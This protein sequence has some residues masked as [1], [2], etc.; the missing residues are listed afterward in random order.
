MRTLVN[1]WE[2][3]ERWL[4]WLA[5]NVAWEPKA[6]PWTFWE[7]LV[8]HPTISAAW[9][10]RQPYGWIVGHLHNGRADSREAVAT[11]GLAHIIEAPLAL[12]LVFIGV[13]I[14]RRA[15]RFIPLS[16]ADLAKAPLRVKLDHAR[17]AKKEAAYIDRAIE[18]EEREEATRVLL[19]ELSATGWLRSTGWPLGYL[20][21]T[22]RMVYLPVARWW[23]HWQI[24]GG[25]GS[26]KTATQAVRGLLHAAEAGPAKDRLSALVF[27]PKA[28][29]EITRLTA[30]VF[31]ARGW[32]VGVWDPTRAGS[33]RWNSLAA[34]P[35][36]AAVRAHMM[37]WAGAAELRHPHY[38]QQA[39]DILTGVALM[40]RED[41]RADGK[42]WST[43][44]MGDVAAFF[45]AHTEEE[46]VAVLAASAR[47]ST[48]PAVKRTAAKL[49]AL[50][51]NKAS[52]EAVMRGVRDALVCLDDPQVR[53]NLRGD[54]ID[55]RAFVAEPTIIYAALDMDAAAGLRPVV[56]T[57]LTGAI[58][59]LTAVSGGR[60]LSRRVVILL[61]EFANLG[62]IDQVEKVASRVRALGIALCL[63]TQGP[64]DVLDV[65]GRQGRRLLANILTTVVLAKTPIE[66][67]KVFVEPGLGLDLD[68]LMESGSA[69]VIRSGE[70]PLHITPQGWYE[71]AG[72]RVRVWWLGRG[73]DKNALMRRQAAGHGLRR[74][75][76]SDAVGAADVGASW[77]ADAEPEEDDDV[78]RHVRGDDDRPGVEND[79]DDPVEGDN[80]DP[81]EDD[82]AR[83]PA[84]A[85]AR[86]VDL[87]W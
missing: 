32:R 6:A 25:T 71:S 23:E 1:L 75:P 59:A 31:R 39:A 46:A 65:Y 67:L 62:Q 42:A 53:E 48:D 21:G 29:H 12:F 81:P 84:S 56:A 11:M 37:Q 44:T 15:T 43:V 34:A 69:A 45:D 41:A 85:A 19:K 57:F 30:G 68:R 76:T 66:S 26:G 40:L 70:R 9:W 47:S 38:R 33:L 49:R 4:A 20:Q 74:A 50:E 24:I 54:D 27:D 78:E 60:R 22:T 8:A 55:W 77:A 87:R 61:D 36:P 63:L 13:L 80:D 2:A 64:R 35:S 83:E 82:A 51:A 14:I 3:H 10:A 52:R 58:T 17:H 79:D 72:T 28:G 86:R 5:Y 18:R 73:M 16:P 7:H